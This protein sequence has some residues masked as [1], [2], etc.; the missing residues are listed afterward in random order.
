M[1]E[2]R[3]VLSGDIYV[4]PST[5]SGGVVGRGN[6]PPG[7]SAFRP[8]VAAKPPQRVEKQVLQGPQAPAPPLAQVPPERLLTPT[9]IQ[10]P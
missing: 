10:H 1:N 6:A 4:A 2:L 8:V 3:S 7:V 9:V 5:R